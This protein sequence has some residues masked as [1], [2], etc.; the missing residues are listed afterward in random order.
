MTKDQLYYLPW[1]NF[2]IMATKRPLTLYCFS[3]PVM[4]V[5]L[6]MEVG[7]AVY[8]LWRYTLTPISR[9]IVALLLLLAGFQG[10][11]FLLCGGLAVQGGV[12]SR[13]GY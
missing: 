13:V 2:G 5:T 9:L 11:E 6:V 3:P 12:W 7:F 8:M 1:Y 10:T 4:L